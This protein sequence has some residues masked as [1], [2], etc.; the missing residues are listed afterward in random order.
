M[1]V[2]DAISQRRSIRDYEDKPVPEEKLNRIL[3]AA[4]LSPSARNNQDRRFIVVRDKEKRLELSRAT[5]GQPHIAQA[6]V[7]IAAVGTKPE[8]H[9][10]MIQESQ[11]AALRTKTGQWSHPP[12]CNNDIDPG[13]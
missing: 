8:Y 2:M 4:R 7:V 3:E 9:M 10:P 1:K 6:P 11:A 5:G 12:G 13:F